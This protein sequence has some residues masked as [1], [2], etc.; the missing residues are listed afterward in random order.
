MTEKE[1]LRAIR[2][3]YPDEVTIDRKKIH[4]AVMDELRRSGLIDPNAPRLGRLLRMRLF[5][6][7]HG[8]QPAPL[9]L[10]LLT[11]LVFVSA[12]ATPAGQVTS[13][14]LK[15]AFRADAPS[16]TQALNVPSTTPEA[17]HR[18]PQGEP[19]EQTSD[20]KN[21]SHPHH[22]LHAL[23]IAHS[24]FSATLSAPLCSAR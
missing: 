15:D 23:P 2:E 12:V 10:T 17:A 11:G 4:T 20:S 13:G 6:S 8:I 7:K 3:L 16:A 1:L 5:L 24:S 22:R 19:C 21:I 9:L 18:Y 14:W